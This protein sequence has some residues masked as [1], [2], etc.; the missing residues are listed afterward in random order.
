[1]ND[2]IRINNRISSCH[3]SLC[4]ASL[5]CAS[6]GIAAAEKM[7]AALVRL[8]LRLRRCA[9][10]HERSLFRKY[11]YP[12]LSLPL[13]AT[14]EPNLSRN[15]DTEF[16]NRSDYKRFSCRFI[17]PPCSIALDFRQKNQRVTASK[18]Q[19]GK[20][21][22]RRKKNIWATNGAMHIY[23]LLLLS[24]LVSEYQYFEHTAHT[25]TPPRE[26]ANS[27]EPSASET[28]RNMKFRMGMNCRSLC[29]W[30]V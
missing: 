28:K 20:K 11:A 10:K 16:S 15:S 27:D 2:S 30:L 22:R 13:F 14:T 4:A 18:H 25:H 26:Q 17:F 1:M 29:S 12:S 3:A 23:I 6:S 8:A 7:R 9:L 24:F 19:T 5:S 21:I